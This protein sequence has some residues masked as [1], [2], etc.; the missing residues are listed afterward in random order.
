MQKYGHTNILLEYV[1]VSDARDINLNMI[2][3]LYIKTNSVI[4]KKNY[5]YRII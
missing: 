3:A 5:I 2:F 4:D 1:P